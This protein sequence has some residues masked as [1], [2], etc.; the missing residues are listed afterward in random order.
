[1]YDATANSGVTF[2]KNCGIDP[3]ELERIKV[4]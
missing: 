1:M 3:I 4:N 2:Q